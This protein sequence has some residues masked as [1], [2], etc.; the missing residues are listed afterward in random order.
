VTELSD[1]TI[2]YRAIKKCWVDPDT[3]KIDAGAFKRKFKQ[4]KNDYEKNL[5]AALEPKHI[6]NK[7]NCFGLICF[8]VADLRKLGLDAIQDKPDRVSIVNVPH[9][10]T[11]KKKAID[12]AR[13]LA[14]K[15]ELFLD[16][17]NNPIKLR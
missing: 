12:I 14:N 15:A 6:Y 17:L 5:S 1:D 11:E 2:L 9:P 8:K 10:E 13:K 3:H 4:L 7:L 16:R